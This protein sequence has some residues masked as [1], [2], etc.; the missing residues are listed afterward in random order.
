[1][2]GRGREVYPW[3]TRL[4]A[5]VGALGLCKELPPARAILTLRLQDATT[6]ASLQLRGSRDLIEFPLAELDVHTVTSV[7]SQS[8]YQCRSLEIATRQ[9]RQVKYYLAGGRH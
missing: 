6:P 5:R 1:M 8:V 4:C 2:K 9:R 3:F 7:H